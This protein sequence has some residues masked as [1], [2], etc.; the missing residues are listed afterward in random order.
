MLNLSILY[1]GLS[2]RCLQEVLVL[3]KVLEDGGGCVGG[4]GK[5]EGLDACHG[6]APNI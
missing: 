3:K 4:E 5:G 6:Y 2:E 1:H